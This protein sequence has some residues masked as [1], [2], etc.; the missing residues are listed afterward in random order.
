MPRPVLAT[1]LVLCLLAAALGL[2]AGLSRA[3]FGEAQAIAAAAADYVAFEA[4]EGRPVAVTDCVGRPGAEVWLVVVC[5]A[6]GRVFRYYV[7]R[8]GRMERSVAE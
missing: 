4:A 6:E 5:G 8:S 2:K 1:T 7:E 3:A